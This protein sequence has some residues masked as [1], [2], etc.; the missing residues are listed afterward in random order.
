MNIQKQIIAD[1]EAEKALVTANR[2]SIKRFEKKIRFSLDRI[3]GERSTK[4]V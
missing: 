3:W 4:E 2:E 1:I